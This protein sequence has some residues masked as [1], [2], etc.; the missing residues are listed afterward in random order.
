[1]WPSQ[2]AL[3]IPHNLCFSYYSIYL[4]PNICRGAFQWCQCQ[5]K[6]SALTYCKVENESGEGRLQKKQCA[7]FSE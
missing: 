2:Y 6:V 5:D 1:M 7:T 3:L 4:F